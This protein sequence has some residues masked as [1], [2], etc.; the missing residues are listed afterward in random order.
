MTPRMIPGLQ[1]LYHFLSTYRS[2]LLSSLL[3]QIGSPNIPNSHLLES[4]ILQNYPGDVLLQAH[5]IYQILFAAIIRSLR[6]PSYAGTI[7]RSFRGW[8]RPPPANEDIVKLLI[9]GNLGAVRKVMEKMTYNSR[10]EALEVF[11]RS[12]MRPNAT[13]NTIPSLSS[14]SASKPQQLQSVL[15]QS[16]TLDFSTL[17]SLDPYLPSLHELFQETSSRLLVSKGVVTSVG[18]ITDMYQYMG[19]MME[20]D[21]DEDENDTEVARS[22]TRT[23]VRDFTTDS[24]VSNERDDAVENSGL[25]VSGSGIFSDPSVELEGEGAETPSSSDANGGSSSEVSSLQQPARQPLVSARFGN[26][27]YFG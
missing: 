25:G 23:A 26:Y 12:I 27:E 1:S 10:L 16:Q 2:I 4:R 11:F 6:P 19:Q 14:S 22:R 3:H 5:Q 24:I 8:Q 9:F 21:D 18:Q 15:G 17:V 13:S 7:E 20:S